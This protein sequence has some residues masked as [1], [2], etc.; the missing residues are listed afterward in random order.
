MS[1]QWTP[2]RGKTGNVTIK[3]G[4][5]YVHV[6]EDGDAISIAMNGR[7]PNGGWAGIDLARLAMPSANKSRKFLNF[8]AR[9]MAAAPE[10]LEALCMVRDADEDCKRDGL[11]TIPA[12]AR[13]KIDAAIAKAE[14]GKP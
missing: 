10:L 8:A 5:W 4:D 9:K 6:D 11:P 13:A 1:A 7:G 3:D 2:G 14:G 12:M